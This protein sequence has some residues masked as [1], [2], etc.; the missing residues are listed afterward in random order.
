MDF[1]S[2]D[3]T[4][5]FPNFVL[6]LD[7]LTLKIEGIFRD[8]CQL[9]GIAVSHQTKDNLGRNIVHEKDINALLYEDAIK[10]LFDEDDLLFFKFLLIEKSGYNLRNKIAHSL[11]SFQEYD[12]DYMH[13]VIL[14]LLRLGKYG[15]TQNNGGLSDE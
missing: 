5:N 15:P 3:P 1:F 14:A 7:S 9:S 11:M 2:A 13:L 8:L 4:R 10:K 12:C 6:S